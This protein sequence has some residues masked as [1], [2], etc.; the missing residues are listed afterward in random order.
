MINS[1]VNATQVGGTHYKVAIQHWDFVAA[2]NLGYFEGQIT[3]YVTRW[4]KKNGA[5]DLQ[6]ARHF[7]LKLIELAKAGYKPVS[8]VATKERSALP[9]TLAEYAEANQLNT[10]EAIVVMMVAVSWGH[11][12][13]LDALES[14][15]QGLDAQLAELESEGGPGPGYVNQDR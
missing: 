9:F 10:W 2:Y 7:T 5:Q 13:K 15:V 6:K 3:K 8:P 4:R 1:E 14:V 12:Q 11:H